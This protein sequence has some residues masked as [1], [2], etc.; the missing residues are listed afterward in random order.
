MLVIDFPL[1]NVPLVIFALVT[2]AIPFVFVPFSVDF[3][4]ASRLYCALNEASFFQHNLKLDINT[5]VCE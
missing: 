5:R 3:S 2:D 1:H 4:S